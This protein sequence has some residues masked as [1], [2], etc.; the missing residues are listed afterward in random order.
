M[1]KF[2][3]DVIH[4]YYP[5]KKSMEQE[6]VYSFIKSLGRHQT[7]IMTEIMLEFLGDSNIRD[8]SSVSKKEIVKI[9]QERLGQNTFNEKKAIREPGIS[10]KDMESIKAMRKKDISEEMPEPVVTKKPE[11]QNEVASLRT[12]D[13][14]PSPVAVPPVKKDLV[15]SDTPAKKTTPPTPK[16]TDVPENIDLLDDDDDENYDADMA[17][18][19]AS[20]FDDGQG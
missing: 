16:V 1:A 13:S 14:Q 4:L 20:M 15:V 17:A 7:E 9:L 8:Y 6:A 2:P 11:T 5:R 3:Y 10:K 12:A 19:V 18:F